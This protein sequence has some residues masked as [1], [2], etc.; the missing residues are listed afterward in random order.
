MAN[1]ILRAFFGTDSYGRT[2]HRAVRSDGTIFERST[3]RNRYGSTMTP[4]RPATDVPALDEWGFNI[5]TEFSS[6]NLPAWRLPLN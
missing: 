4:W 5:L 3:S 1:G 2:V 6:D